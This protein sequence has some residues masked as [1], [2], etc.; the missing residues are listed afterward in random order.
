[1]AK[2]HFPSEEAEHY[3]LCGKQGMNTDN[4]TYM[5]SDVTC[6]KCNTALYDMGAAYNE[7]AGLSTKRRGKFKFK[8]ASWFD[9]QDSIAKIYRKKDAIRYHISIS[10]TNRIDIAVPLEKADQVGKNLSSQVGKFKKRHGLAFRTK[11]VRE[12]IKIGND[13]RMRFTITRVT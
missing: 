13:A 2:I 4:S 10:G 12:K 7:S 9:L 11:M 5:T 1:M 6:I 3:G 8:Q